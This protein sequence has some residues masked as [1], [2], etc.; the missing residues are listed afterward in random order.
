MDIPADRPANWIMII[1]WIGS[2]LITLFSKGF[3]LWGLVDSIKNKS[4]TRITQYSWFVAVFILGEIGAL[5]YYFWGEP[6][7]KPC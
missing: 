5:A 6:V 3:W 2:V 7:D 4:V 1:Q